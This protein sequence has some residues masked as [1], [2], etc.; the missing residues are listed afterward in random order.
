MHYL[1]KIKHFFKGIIV[2]EISMNRIL[3]ATLII[4]SIPWHI[5][6]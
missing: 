2:V 6:C 5:G 1:K 3:I 4:K